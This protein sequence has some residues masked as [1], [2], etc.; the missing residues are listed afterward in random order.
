GE[1]TGDEA[2]G[3]VPRPRPGG[4]A[5]GERLAFATGRAVEGLQAG[6]HDASD[7][8]ADLRRDRLTAV[9]EVADVDGQEP[10]A[11]DGQTLQTLRCGLSVLGAERKVD[12]G[13][14]GERVVEEER[15]ARVLGGGPLGEVPVV[16]R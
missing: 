12:D 3:E 4:G 15:L 5:E 2:L 10:T 7:A 11:V 1:A 6:D 8:R 13:V 9:D 14:F 16:G